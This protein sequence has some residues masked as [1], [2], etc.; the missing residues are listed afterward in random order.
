MAYNY[1]YPGVNM[2][3]YNNDWLINKVK[4]LATEWKSLQAEWSDEK[5]SL[6]DLKNYIMS[7]FENLNVDDEINAKI[8]SLVADGTFG[9]IL[10]SYVK[11]EGTPVFVD[12]V[13]LMTDKSRVYVLKENGHI[14]TYNGTVFTDTGFVY[15]SDP[16]AL[17]GFTTQVTVPSILSDANDA[18]PNHIYCVAYD[19]MENLPVTDAIGGVL[20]C[21]NYVTENRGAYTQLF[22]TRTA[23]FYYRIK[24]GG[25]GGVWS[26]WIHASSSV[27]CDLNVQATG[28]ITYNGLSDADDAEVNRIYTINNT[29]TI[30]NLPDGEYNGTMFTMNYTNDNRSGTVQLFFSINGAVYSRIR[31]GATPG[32]FFPWYTVNRPDRPKIHPSMFLKWAGI[33][34]S[35]ISGVCGNFGQFY[36]LSWI[37][38][39]ARQNG[40]ECADY[41]RG[42]LT[43][44]SWL[45]D[46]EGLEAMNKDTVPANLYF[47]AFGINDSG[48][49]HHVELGS[50]A[51]LNS[52]TP[53]DTFYGNMRKIHDAVIAKNNNAVLCYVT[54]PR[55]GDRY[56]PYNT[57][58][59]AIAEHYNALLLDSSDVAL[60]RS[61][62]WNNNMVEQHPTAVQYSAMA[63]AYGDLLSDELYRKIDLLTDYTG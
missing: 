50:E 47:I 24:W 45:T 32:K 54:I 25:S 21:L 44:A 41:S 43:T 56:E 61:D 62:W 22:I 29:G 42:G 46:K 57:A 28:S 19:G 35:F 17:V 8:D 59:R 9:E 55:S 18:T 48:T 15:S 39:L 52:A 33:G 6:E 13:S 30:A 23:N 11:D 1:E 63:A 14:Y 27:G 36:K 58:I 51:D 2:N 40:V 38:N 3:D 26:N 20:L 37:Q 60:F 12:N 49:T 31:W 5:Q 10:S 4:E 34:D 16:T 53:P 7:Y